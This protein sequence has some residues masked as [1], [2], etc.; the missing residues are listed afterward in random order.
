M[1]PSLVESQLVS[2]GVATLQWNEEAQN[3][4]FKLI[5]AAVLPDYKKAVIIPEISSG[6][7]SPEMLAIEAI[8]L[9]LNLPPERGPT[10][11]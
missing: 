2:K 9:P 1:N 7:F 6:L 4:D 11:V 10:S 5:I 8:Y 3:Y